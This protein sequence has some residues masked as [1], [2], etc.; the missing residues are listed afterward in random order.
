MRIDLRNLPS[1]TA[2]LHQLVRDMASVVERREDEIEQLQAIIEDAQLQLV[3]DQAR[4]NG[5]EHLSE[6]EA[7]RRG[8]PHARL[9]VI[10][11]T[12]RRKRLQMWPHAHRRHEEDWAMIAKMGMGDEQG[13]DGP[14]DWGAP[15]PNPNPNPKPSP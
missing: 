3:A 8:H 2:L 10:T 9:V 12:A 4:V 7:A 13:L 1:D 14:M 5:V 11:A 6:H 15:S